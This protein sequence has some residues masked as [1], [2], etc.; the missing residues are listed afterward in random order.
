MAMSV[1]ARNDLLERNELL[2]RL[3]R[4]LDEARA[5]RGGLVLLG[6]EAGAGKTALV[7]AFSAE[8]AAARI[9]A[10]ACDSLF[11]PRPLAPF[12]DIAAELGGALAT[13]LAA[14]A[15]PDEL[16]RA[17]LAELSAGGRPTLLVLEDMHWADE[18]TLDVLRV[19][20]R[21]VGA[22][23]L[24]ILVT[25]RDDELAQAHPLRLVLGELATRPSVVRLAVPALSQ[26]AVAKL[27]GEGGM[28][29][30]K[31]HKLTGGNP[32]FVTE[33]IA[34]GDE[35]IPPT[36]LDA[37]LARAARLT[38]EARALL[39]AVAIAPPRVELWLLDA[40]ADEHVA[41]LEECL[42][43]GMLVDRA[44]AIEF[45]HDLARLAVEESLSLRR[46]L[47]LHQRALEALA[48]P[49]TGKP[50]VARLAHHA[51]AGGD[52]EAVLR[53]AP[54]AAE[55][56]AAL[57]AHYEAAAQY[58]RALRFA[59]ELDPARRAELL[60]RH[61]V[62]CYLTT[63][64]REAIE[65]VAA[66][67]VL[68]RQ[69][70]E[71][72]RLGATLRWQALVLLNKGMAHD[73]EHA[74]REAVS[75]LERLPPHHELAMTHIV[76]ASLANLNDLSEETVA[77]ANRGLELAE[78]VGSTEA[79]VAAQATLG[80]RESLD[81]GP[82]G[83]D[84]LEETLDEAR[85]AGLET[86]VG[87]TYVFMGMAA[88]RERSLAR[89]RQSV[90]PGL[91]FCDERQVSLWDD[92]LLVMRGWLE[93]EAGDWD[94][95]AVTVQEVLA[96]NCLLSSTQAKVVL[97]L[98]RARRGDPDPWTPLAEA[99]EVAERTGQ[100]WWTSLVA[101]AQA[102]AAWLEGRRN[103]VAEL[104]REPFELA[105][106]RGSQ[107][108][109]AEL[110]YWRARA[111]VEEDVVNDAV[112]PF[113]CMARGE[114]AQAAETWHDLGCPYEEAL[115]LSEADDPDALQRALEQARRLGASPLA[116]IAARRLRERG[117][118][119]ARGPRP[120]TRANAAS[121]TARELEVLQLLGAGLR[122]A[123]IAERLF[124]SR[125]TVDHHVAAI[126]RKLEAGT[127]GE[128][129][130]QAARLGLVANEQTVGPT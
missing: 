45:R 123:A 55:Q 10:G 29:A 73:A 53:F 28:D 113:G 60:T 46:R 120:T 56:A 84:R 15:R 65:S 109:L 43:S 76:L 31:L 80:L 105:L 112:G 97:G 114:W 75:V 24:L 119:V 107:A 79:R 4:G 72:L 33:A 115:A 8:Q 92:I 41:A 58:A 99:A 11:T 94:D 89:V 90:L 103:E 20:S 26:A 3:G 91:A 108:P 13:L 36:V 40:I 82:G 27:A 85:R 98:L 18:G 69:L 70:G 102:E 64:D 100:L 47:L 117:V 50:D 81:G 93:L 86:Q 95:A 54:A 12:A 30:G 59:G 14:A 37:V 67:S 96:R 116:A 101:A 39:E 7:D 83:W 125:R 77:S 19:L 25:Y 1:A 61:S 88:S 87:R 34:A 74:A 118:R 48:D 124:L 122:N 42:A 126:L 44:N 16:V 52:I 17:L 2:E 49:P 106:E 127:R 71:E 104:T 110:A 32:F 128:A 63:Q 57:G 66:A 78:R 38:D 51:D 62:E 21:K 111:G 121:L 22:T 23:R 129:V 130:A 5:G 35:T 6:G 9:L 68:Y